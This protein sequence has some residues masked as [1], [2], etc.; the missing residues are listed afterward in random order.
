MYKPYLIIIL[1]CMILVSCTSGAKKISAISGTGSKTASS[2]KHSNRE[3]VQEK[4]I[5]TLLELV[6]PEDKPLFANFQTA[7]KS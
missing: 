3:I 6:N 2:V 5:N 7:L 1:S 4:K